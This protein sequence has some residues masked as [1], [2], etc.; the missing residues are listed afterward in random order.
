MIQT[1][2]KKRNSKLLKKDSNINNNKC[3]KKFNNY[4]NKRKLNKKIFKNL[5]IQ[6]LKYV[7]RLNPINN[8]KQKNL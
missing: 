6:N 8:K 3:K 1:E 4:K 2:L 7:M 5:L